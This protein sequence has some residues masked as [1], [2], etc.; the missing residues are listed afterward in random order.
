MGRE[1]KCGCPVFSWSSSHYVDFS[2]QFDTFMSR[3]FKL[4]IKGPFSFL[5][6][7]VFLFLSLIFEMS[8]VPMLNIFSFHLS[9]KFL[10][11]K[12]FNFTIKLCDLYFFFREYLIKLIKDYFCNLI[13]QAITFVKVLPWLFLNPFVKVSF[14]GICESH[15]LLNHHLLGWLG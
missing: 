4:F 14:F 8:R 9:W 12:G 15:C 3:I 10:Q 6:Y 1:R 5:L 7:S 13:G 11:C 2:H